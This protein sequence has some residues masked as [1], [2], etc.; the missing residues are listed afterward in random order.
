L[1]TFSA[2]DPLNLVGVVV[3]G[4]REA[5]G[6]GRTVAFHDGAGVRAGE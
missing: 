1:V 3:P 5:A 4:D 2:A 6:S